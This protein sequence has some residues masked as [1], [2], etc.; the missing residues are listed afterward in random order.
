MKRLKRSPTTPIQASGL[1]GRQGGAGHEPVMNV[2]RGNVIKA[3]AFV[4][5]AGKLGFT[6]VELVKL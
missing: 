3:G 1:P 4:P 5:A 2:T 6:D